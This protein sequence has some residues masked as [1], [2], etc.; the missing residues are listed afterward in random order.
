MAAT[1][2]VIRKPTIIPHPIPR[3][4]S[5]VSDFQVLLKIKAATMRIKSPIN[6]ISQ[7]IKLCYK[8]IVIPAFASAALIFSISL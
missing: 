4:K 3:V 8:S 7:S 2:V 6:I 5:L 1:P